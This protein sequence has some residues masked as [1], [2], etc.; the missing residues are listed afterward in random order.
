M[1]ITLSNIYLRNN[2]KYRTN[3]YVLISI[4]HGKKNS[5]EEIHGIGKQSYGTESRGIV[6]IFGDHKSKNQKCRN[7]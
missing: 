3:L 6:N 5:I 4:L 1:N 7:I 2:Q